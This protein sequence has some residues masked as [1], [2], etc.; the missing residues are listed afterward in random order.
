MKSAFPGYYKPDFDELWSKCTFVPD[1][2]VLLN[3]YGYSKDT[4]EDLVSLFE[5]LAPR[6]W[7]PHQFA[8][9]YHRNRPRAILEQVGH[10]NDIEKQLRAIQDSFESRN[11]HPFVRDRT[12]LKAFSRLQQDL[13]SSR[14]EL[15]ELLSND[16][17]FRRISAA[18]SGRVGPEPV[19]RTA[20]HEAARVRYK[21]KT[22]PG[23]EDHPEKPE[24]ACFGDFLG[25]RQILEHAKS[26][27]VPVVLVTD[28]A[29][30]DWWLIER[31]RTLGPRPEL[32]SEF[33]GE[34][35]TQFYM[36]SSAQF[37]AY[38]KEFLKAQISDA[39]IEE[40]QERQL[41][42]NSLGP[43][44]KFAERRLASVQAALESGFEPNDALAPKASA[45]EP[46]KGAPRPSSTADAKST[47]T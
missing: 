11:R 14:K 31:S 35:G 44:E 15:E 22:P 24:P 13:A 19:D 42:T 17:Y 6:V 4:R 12:L 45:V 43:G 2:N 33:M 5:R 28:D 41:S 29:K 18:F 32:M 21:E 23:Y 37:L 38:A 9:E 16:P 27:V 7:I 10:Y 8:F 46:E 34:C 3:V 25:W 47:N 39:A 30:G 36:Y 20:L 1:A 26:C 40:V